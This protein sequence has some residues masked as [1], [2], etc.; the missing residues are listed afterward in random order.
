MKI[1]LLAYHLKGISG[2]ARHILR[3]AREMTDMGHEVDV[4][5]ME[6]DP[7]KCYPELVEGINVQAIFPLEG[8][9][10]M[11]TDNMAAFLRDQ[12]RRQ[13]IQQQMFEQMP[14]GYDIINPH[15][16]TVN[17]AAVQYKRRYGAPVVWLCN[18]LWVPGGSAEERASGG[19]K[20][21]VKDTMT[22]NIRQLDHDTVAD[23]DRVVVLSRLVAEPFEAEY[24]MKPVIIPTGVDPITF[25][26]D[27]SRAIR[28][29]YGFDDGI[30]LLLTA[31]MLME[32]RRTEDVIAAVAKLAEAGR[33]IGYLIVGK[34]SFRPDYVA[35]LKA[36]VQR[37]GMDDRIKFAGEVAP[38]DLEP[39]LGAGDTFVWAADAS[40]SWGM[41]CLEAMTAGVPAIVSDSN[42]LAEALTHDQDAL[43][44]KGEDI[45]SLVTQITRLMDD[46]DLR[47]RISAAGQQLAI[48]K[49]SWRG[50]AHAML[51]VF[52]AVGAGERESAS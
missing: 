5:A 37:L 15:G 19:I 51:D 11:P 2:I 30:F 27:A 50:N 45:D 8:S 20:Q 52:Q 34:E 25:D 12:R 26:V 35:R 44:Y 46:A 14:S 16:H 1:A 33:D 39:S 6:Y 47:G 23:I 32:R 17:Q 28:R 7:E 9:G 40:Q 18:D 41:G 24:A 3:Q 48:D 29:R 13:R 43:L 4:W 22:R 49:Y 21:M 10:A 42:G 36:D 38:E 31:A